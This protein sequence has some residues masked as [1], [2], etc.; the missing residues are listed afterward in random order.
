MAEQELALAEKLKKLAGALD[1]LRADTPTLE[2]LLKKLVGK[3][4]QIKILTAGI[5]RQSGLSES[6]KENLLKK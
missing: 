1:I 6:K 3:T 4:N 2:K 5:A